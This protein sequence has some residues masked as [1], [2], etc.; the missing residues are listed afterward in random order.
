MSFVSERETLKFLCLL[1]A[2]LLSIN[3]YIF[4][5]CSDLVKVNAN[6]YSNFDA[7]ITLMESKRMFAFVF[8]FLCEC[9]IAI[10]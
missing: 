2:M 4:R 1:Q 7:L 9:Y 8:A 5:T 10:S 3:E 6:G